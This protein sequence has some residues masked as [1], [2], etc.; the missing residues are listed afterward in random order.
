[1]TKITII[2][3]VVALAGT[4]GLTTS[5][6]GVEVIKVTGAKSFMMSKVSVELIA[7]LIML[8]AE[9]TKSV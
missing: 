8:A 4:A 3:A 7:A 9:A 2:A 6:V 1:M 5:T